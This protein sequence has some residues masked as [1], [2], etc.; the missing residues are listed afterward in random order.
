MTW[1]DF[2][3]VCLIVGGALASLSLVLGVLHVDLPRHF[4]HFTVGHHG[5]IG[6][7]S[8]GGAHPAASAGAGHSP[9][10]FPMVMSFLAWFGGAGFLLV[11]SAP[12]GPVL[13]FFG[14]TL[15]GLVGAGVVFLF[16]ARVLSAHDHSMRASDY[17]LPGVLGTLTLAIREGGTGEITYVQ[18]GTRKSAAAR[19]ED[20]AAIANGREVVVLRFVEGV[21]YVRRWEDEVM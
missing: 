17:H 7:P 1:S 5:P 13:A 19:A 9:V 2:Y 3:L 18:G 11:R 6:H 16:V 8:H 12:I 14:A 20:G 10:S 21:A 4:G 15:S